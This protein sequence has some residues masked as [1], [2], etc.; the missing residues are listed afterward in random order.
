MIRS[1]FA[2]V[3]RTPFVAASRATT[4]KAPALVHRF[5]SDQATPEAAPVQPASSTK[6]IEA[7]Q[8]AEAAPAISAQD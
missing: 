1:V 6:S 8:D 2:G 7:K 4:Y 5:Y 3:C